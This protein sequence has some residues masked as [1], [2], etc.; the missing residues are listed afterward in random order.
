MGR[1]VTLHTG[2]QEG[3]IT[4]ECRPDL[5]D[6][7]PGDSPRVMPPSCLPASL[8]PLLPSCRRGVFYFHFILPAASLENFFN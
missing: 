3:I 6:S 1:V 7:S 4:L 8:P 2:R 5:D